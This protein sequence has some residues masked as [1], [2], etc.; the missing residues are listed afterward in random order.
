M[1]FN[2]VLNE[3]LIM[4]VE[5]EFIAKSCSRLWDKLAHQGKVN[6]NDEWKFYAFEKFFKSFTKKHNK[7]PCLKDALGFIRTNF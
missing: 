6:L 2:K 7:E 3:R 1:R 5:D 4:I